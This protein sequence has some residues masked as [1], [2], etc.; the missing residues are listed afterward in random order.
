MPHTYVD[1]KTFPIAPAPGCRDSHAL[2]VAAGKAPH[3]L[4]MSCASRTMRPTVMSEP[5]V[6][7]IYVH[8]YVIPLAA[9]RHIHWP[10]GP[11]R[12]HGEADLYVD[13]C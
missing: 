8:A 4:Q 5:I 3:A 2:P 13:T 12:I 11:G 6:T 7:D 1:K 10:T 9:S